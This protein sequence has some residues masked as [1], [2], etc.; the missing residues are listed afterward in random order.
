MSIHMKA[1]ARY[2][3]LT[4]NIDKLPRAQRKQAIAD[5]EKFGGRYVSKSESSF[6]RPCLILRF[7]QEVCNIPLW[8]ARE[9]V[10]V[11]IQQYD[12]FSFD[13]IVLLPAALAARIQD[14]TGNVLIA[15]EAASLYLSAAE[16]TR[17]ARYWQ[18]VLNAIR[19]GVFVNADEMPS[20]E[21][22]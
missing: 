19:W 13:K 4:G 12:T 8:Q 3:A 21:E 15:E 14:D 18:D 1:L 17:W 2:G 16:G 10:I 6:D 11:M 9:C 20:A 22:K 7:M 5:R